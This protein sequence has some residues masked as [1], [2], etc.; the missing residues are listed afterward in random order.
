VKCRPD[1]KKRPINPQMANLLI[2]IKEPDEREL[3]IFTLRFAGY[4]MLAARSE[5]E[6]FALARQEKPDLILLD[7]ALE[8]GGKSETLL[9]L[10]SDPET[11]D[12]RV[13][14]L[15]AEGQSGEG[16][17]DLEDRR[18]QTVRRPISPDQLTRRINRFLKRTEV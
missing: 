1:R 9:A 10:R 7:E 3:V 17:A 4:H 16:L 13:M 6:L 8:W 5:G 18:V 15:L 2:A 11:R 12:M 14:L